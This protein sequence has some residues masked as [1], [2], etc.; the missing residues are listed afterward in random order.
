[1]NFI[2]TGTEYDIELAKNDTPCKI[3]VGGKTKKFVPN[4]NFSKWDDICWMNVNHPDVVKNETTIEEGN[5][6]SLTIG[7]TR[8]RYYE[9]RGYLEYDIGWASKPQV[10]RIDLPLL[11]PEGLTFHKQPTLKDEFEK[12]PNEHATFEEF[13]LHTHRPDN[14]VGSYAVYWKDS[15][16]NTRGQD[17]RT[18]KFGHI[19]RPLVSDANGNTTWAELEVVDNILGITVDQTWLNTAQYP[20]IIDP[21]FG[22]FT[23]GDSNA[24]HDNAYIYAS[25]KGTGGAGTTVTIH[26]YYN[27]GNAGQDVTV[28][29]YTDSSGP[30]SKVGTED[31]EADIGTQSVAWKAFP[32]VETISAQ[33][34]WIGVQWSV[35]Y[36][37]D[38]RYDATTAHRYL[39]THTY[40]TAWPATYVSGIDSD[41]RYTYYC[42]Y[43]AGGS[44]PTGNINGPLVG[45]LGGVI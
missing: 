29:L 32:Y 9:N 44:T 35:A 2:K 40:G 6:V 42:T 45:P 20:V 36:D 21:T 4:I 31:E 11:F 37:S 25:A 26:V 43:T 1:M 10:N 41:R 33:D 17:F 22:N 7:D 3:K 14:V 13:L 23:T 38:V 8:H 15:W 19:Y 27:N 30:S 18:G 12:Y 39:A 16:S 24:T 34:Y 28:C 5:K